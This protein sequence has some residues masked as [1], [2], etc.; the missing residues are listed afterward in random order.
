V[1]K[2]KKNVKT[3]FYI[4]DWS[5]MLE[6]TCPC[7]RQLERFGLRRICQEFF[8]AALP[9]PS[10]HSQTDKQSQQHHLHPDCPAR[11]TDMLGKQDV[12]RSYR[13]LHW[14]TGTL[15]H[16]ASKQSQSET[17]N[18]RTVHS[19]Y[20]YYYYYYKRWCL[21]WRYHAQN[22]AGPPNKH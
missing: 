4:Y 6:P 5:K 12:I 7:W 14:W 17:Q 3:F 9:A 13:R 20:Y 11:D 19:H 22:V 18:T 10:L 21:G 15:T 8:S 2:I 1:T 16:T